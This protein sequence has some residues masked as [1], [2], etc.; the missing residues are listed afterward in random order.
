MQ[1]IILI[2][3]HSS[4]QLA[5]LYEHLYCTRLKELFYEHKLYKYLDYA[6]SGT[7]FNN[8]GLIEI[9]IELYTPRA[10]ALSHLLQQQK[11]STNQ[12]AVST[13]FTQI[14]AEEESSISTTGF[15]KVQKA[16][17][18][19][20]KS[21]WQHIDDFDTF[22]AKAAR[23][24]RPP[25]YVD[26]SHRLPTRKITTTLSLERQFAA[27]H[28]ELIPLFRHIAKLVTFTTQDQLALE[29]GY[30]NDEVTF[31]STAQ[32]THIKSILKIANLAN[33]T[34]DLSRDMAHYQ[35]ICNRMYTTNAFKTLLD[36]LRSTSYT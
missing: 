29:H 6:L 32:R 15:E 33:E 16:L 2:K 31:R 36:E 27:T 26:Y 34:V 28:R 18:G 19:L 21:A 4:V 8:G 12:A 17:V 20:G 11:I 30:Y 10:I 3:T 14:L 22:D 9:D 23:Q 35:A 1:K 25:V 13:A 24:K 5:H 7:T